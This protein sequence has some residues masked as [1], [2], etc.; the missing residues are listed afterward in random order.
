MDARTNKIINRFKDSWINTE[1]FYDDLINNYPG[2]ERL[3]PLRKFILKLKDDNEFNNFRLGTSM[4]TLVIS[5]SVDHGLRKDQKHIKI[6]S[7]SEDDFEVVMM[8][9][10]KKYREFRI[11]NFED[12]RLNKLLKILSDTLVD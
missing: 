9:G 1:S 2:F 6:E 7:L 11:K 10:E 8:D 12:Q 3:K 5:R 4:H